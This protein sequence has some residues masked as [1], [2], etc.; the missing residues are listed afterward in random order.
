M[1]R[2]L[3]ALFWL[4]QAV[5]A[6]ALELPPIPDTY[7]Y[8]SAQILSPATR[9]GL[10]ERLAA[11]ERD[12]SNQV[13]VATFPDLQGETIEEFSI[14]LAEKWKPGQKGREN[15]A[16][17]VVSKGDRKV[18]IEVGYG[19]EGVLP[20]AVAKSI[21]HNEILPHFKGGYFDAGIVAGI[22]A[23]LKASAGEYQG[24]GGDKTAPISIGTILFLVILFFFVILP[25][26]RGSSGISG[27]G[28]YRGSPWTFG[29]GGGGWGSRSGGGGGGGFSSG[30][31]SFGGGGAS[32]GW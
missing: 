17:L 9:Q 12:S 16:I 32:G 29:G 26:L 2:L 21:L 20:D 23:I 8:D 3:F 7:I 10:E 30:G 15:G 14:R 4:F 11:F 27:R 18:R 6:F 28:P 5:P 22:E 1:I 24:S 19:L 31:G 25:L 13:L